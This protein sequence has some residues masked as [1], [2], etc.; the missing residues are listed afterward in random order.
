MVMC[1]FAVAFTNDINND[2]LFSS[3]FGRKII[4]KGLERFAEVY[5]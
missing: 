1:F 5:Q 4:F 3:S 2:K